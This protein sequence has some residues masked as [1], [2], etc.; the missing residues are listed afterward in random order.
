MDKNPMF[1]AYAKEKEGEY[2]NNA[3]SI[4]HGMKM[5]YDAFVEEGFTHEQALSLVN[6]IVATFIQNASRK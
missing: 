3:I 5:Q 4:A 1:E 6:S 2:K